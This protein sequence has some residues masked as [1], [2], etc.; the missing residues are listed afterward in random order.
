MSESEFRKKLLRKASVVALAG[1]MM[2][3]GIG[4]TSTSVLQTR[5][6][7]QEYMLAAQDTR[8]DREVLDSLLDRC[9]G[10]TASQ[11]RAFSKNLRVL[12]GTESG[13]I[14]LRRLPDEVYF[15]VSPDL[16]RTE[17]SFVL[18]TYS[19]QDKK[20]CLSPD[21]FSSADRDLLTV[22]LAHEIGHAIQDDMRVGER[23]GE[24]T[25]FSPFQA[26]SLNK[27]TEAEMFA[28]SLD[29]IYQVKKNDTSFFKEIFLQDDIIYS[30][31]MYEGYAAAYEK[32]LNY[33]KELGTQPARAD[34]YARRKTMGEFVEIMLSP[35][36]GGE[37]GMETF[38]WDLSY[39]LQGAQTV[40]S[41]LL[42]YPDTLSSEG[43][44]ALYRSLL[45]Q[46]A[47][48]L[49]M[50]AEKLENLLKDRDLA[51]FLYQPSA[52]LAAYE[53][54]D[55]Q[56][57]DL[58]SFRQAVSKTEE[59]Q[60]VKEAFLSPVQETLYEKIKILPDVKTLA[61]LAEKSNSR[62]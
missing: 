5:E 19:G 10:M 28:Y 8:T 34:A 54:G 25:S 38:S 24:D 29:T 27:L 36:F 45:K 31:K 13:N 22:A 53:T 18:G 15:E 42:L 50:E 46:H 41:I 59:F 9:V 55:V 40:D 33:F 4:C 2:F 43:N 14:L 32:N 62:L 39:D 3:A 56:K 37:Y 11:K 16:K 20:I 51:Y 58:L 30:Q 21:V 17:D 61:L 23:S 12:M 1:A 47:D 52:V 6:N 60:A 7:L 57:E 26:A 35:I 44:D 48:G 49:F